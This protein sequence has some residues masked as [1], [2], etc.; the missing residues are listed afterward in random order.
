MRGEI[1]E[2]PMP[3]KTPRQPTYLGTPFQDGKIYSLSLEQP[4]C[5]EA[6]YPGS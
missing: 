6:C 2:E 4:A 1:T 3:L 5:A